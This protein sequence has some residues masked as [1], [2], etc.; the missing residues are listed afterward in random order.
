MEVKMRNLQVCFPVNK[1]VKAY[2]S[3]VVD[4]RL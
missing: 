4:A 1:E 3:M 2:S